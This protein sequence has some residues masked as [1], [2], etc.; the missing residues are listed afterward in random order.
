MC[1]DRAAL[2][3][4]G[5]QFLVHHF[6]DSCV[7]LTLMQESCPES[8]LSSLG[9]AVIVGEFLSS[10][11]TGQNGA[12]QGTSL[13]C[14]QG[15]LLSWSAPRGQMSADRKIWPALW[16]A[17][18][19]EMEMIVCPRIALN[20]CGVLLSPNQ[21]ARLDLSGFRCKQAYCE[22]SFI[23]IY[24]LARSRELFWVPKAFSQFVVKTYSHGK[25]MI[26]HT[27]WII[28]IGNIAVT[29][30]DQETKNRKNETW[31]FG[32]CF[33]RYLLRNSKAV[34]YC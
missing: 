25:S 15:T 10:L 2:N 32:F 27:H 26:C 22:E 24:F 14:G 30:S 13:F 12:D 18:A 16:R 31:R 3:L 28:I 8:K 11:S 1:E 23:F 7:R 17:Q 29:L 4:S 9:I 6:I 19:R 33:P 21:F 5:Q 20:I 34:S